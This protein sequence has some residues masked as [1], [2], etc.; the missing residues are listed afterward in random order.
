MTNESL[1]LWEC[2]S[3]AQVS[4]AELT[5]DLTA[6]VV[7]I[8][9]GF[10]GLSAALHLAKA[11]ASVCLLEARTIGFGGSGRNVGLVNAGL[12]T[13]P[14]QISETIGAQP[15]ERL[16]GR[17]G[18]AP[19]LVFGLIDE[20]SI[21]C[22]A[23]QRGT[24]HLAHAPRGVRDLQS[25]HDQLVKHGAPVRILDRYET[26]ARTGSEAFFGACLDPRAGTV[27]PL[28]YAKGL[29]RAAI[30]AGAQV[31][32][33]TPALDITSGNDH[34]LVKTRKH[35]VAARH[36]V[37]A[38]NAYETR[39]S[40]R[41]RFTPVFY[42]QFATR[43]LPDALRKD[44]LPGGEGCWDTALVMSS[45]RMDAQGRLVLGGMGRLDGSCGAVHHG[46]A[47]RKL[48]LLFPRLGDV[49]FE[50]EWCGRIAMTGDHLPRIERMGENA[51]S[52]Y[53]YSGRGIAPGTLF[54]KSVA[55]WII[56]GDKDVLPVEMSPPRFES[57][58]RAKEAFFDMGSAA[59]HVVA[60]RF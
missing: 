9:A 18:N 60:A 44:V 29:A 20:H 59:A 40:D 27:Q 39:P 2:S 46:W 11:G 23:T 52:I 22:Q 6:D 8:G 5:Q 49:P 12:W 16:I 54:G 35:R 17:L 48:R 47:R 34:W 15:A 45:F 26:R 30:K 7:I 21:D 56:T 57:W 1:N 55:D 31:F 50:F 4:T 24:L 19:D 41:A 10:T 13:P 32:Q 36:L 51:V 42:S 14:D 33:H 43:P 3:G 25:R 37:H 28:A 58:P 53:G 38:T